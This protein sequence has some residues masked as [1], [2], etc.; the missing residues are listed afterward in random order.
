M[1]PGQYTGKSDATPA[2]DRSDATPDGG[3][4]S[5]PAPAEGPPA[6][7]SLGMA[8]RP[9]PARSSGDRVRIAIWLG[10]LAVLVAGVIMYFRFERTVVP[11]VGGGR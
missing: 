5:S 9:T 6:R 4:G 2:D 10:A 8:G 1:E 3:A 7:P 11:L